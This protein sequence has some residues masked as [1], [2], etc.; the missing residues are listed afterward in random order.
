MTPEMDTDRRQDAEREADEL[1]GSV[2]VDEESVKL[3]LRSDIPD[4]DA[5]STLLLLANR[6]KNL[7][8]KELT[9]LE[10]ELDSLISNRVKYPA[11]AVG[12]RY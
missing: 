8:E 6:Y 4:R 12:N 10:L 1:V 5:R 7:T 2:L 11:G 3:I 9:A